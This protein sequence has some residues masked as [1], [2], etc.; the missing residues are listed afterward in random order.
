MVLFKVFFLLKAT[1]NHLYPLETQGSQ[2]QLNVAITTNIHCCYCVST[3]HRK[4]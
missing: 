4:T 1:K 3:L 2:V